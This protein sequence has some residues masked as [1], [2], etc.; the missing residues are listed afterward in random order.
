L[1]KAIVNSPC[2][3]KLSGG[4]NL[5]QFIIVIIVTVLVKLLWDVYKEQMQ[6]KNN[7]RPSQKGGEV[8]DLSNAWIDLDDMPYS[9]REHLLPGRELAVY[10]LLLELLP[11]ESYVV[12]P[13]VRLADV[14]IVSPEAH[15]RIEHSNR[16][17]ERNLDLLICAAQDLKPLA[18][19]TFEAEVEGKKKQLADRFTRKALE[20]MGLPCLDLRPGSPPSKSELITM[21]HKLGLHF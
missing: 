6:K 7:S 2:N 18:A 15:N 4:N 14:A 8:I 20:A 10:H 11:G 17:R 3:L 19:I 13:R 21:L 12:L 9:R 16:I 5:A 1:R